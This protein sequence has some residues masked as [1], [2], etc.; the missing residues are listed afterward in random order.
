MIECVRRCTGSTDKEMF[1]EDLKGSDQLKLK[2]KKK[3][4][5]VTHFNGCVSISTGAIHEPT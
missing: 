5:I 4:E 2:Q 1:A 3:E